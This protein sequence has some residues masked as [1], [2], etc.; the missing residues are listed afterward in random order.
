M[1]REALS[2]QLPVC[3]CC[4]Y[5]GGPAIL[6]AY[7]RGNSIEPLICRDKQ[8]RTSIL[9]GQTKRSAYLQAYSSEHP[10]PQ[11]PKWS[12]C[13]ELKGTA[14]CLVRLLPGTVRFLI[15]RPPVRDSMFMRVSAILAAFSSLQNDNN[16][17]FLH[18]SNGTCCEF[19]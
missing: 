5:P 2:V 12:K 6:L 14:N 7:C 16:S 10:P 3:G 17:R 4:F 11:L 18:S 15:D 8:R 19:P 13:L 1:L 9:A